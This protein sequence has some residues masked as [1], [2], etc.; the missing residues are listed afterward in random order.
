MSLGFLE[1]NVKLTLLKGLGKKFDISSNQSHTWNHVEPM[2]S[3]FSGS[4][5]PDSFKWMPTKMNAH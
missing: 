3:P 5:I 4:A 1:K 2:D